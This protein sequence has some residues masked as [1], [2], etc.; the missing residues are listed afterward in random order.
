MNR[1]VAALIASTLMLVAADRC[2][3]AAPNWDLDY[4]VW[5]GIPGF[6]YQLWVDPPNG[7]A[8]V[9]GTYDTQNQA[10]NDWFFLVEH[11]AFPPGTQ[12]WTQVIQVTE[13]HYWDTYETYAQAAGS[14]CQARR[15]AS[16]GAA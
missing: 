16:I 11:N 14:A 5:V 13:W 12:Y 2:H 1:A 6:N 3:A 10:N 7:P 9:Y 8:F 15:A 4:E